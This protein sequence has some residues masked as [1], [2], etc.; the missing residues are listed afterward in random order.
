MSLLIA[1]ES[2]APPPQVESPARP[3]L[4]S[5]VV[6]SPAALAAGAPAASVDVLSGPVHLLP[7]HEGLH[8]PEE[9]LTTTRTPGFDGATLLDLDDRA[10]VS[11]DPL[12]VVLPLS[13]AAPDADQLWTFL[14]QFRD[15]LNG[16]LWGDAQLA[17]SF[18]DGSTWQLRFRHEAAQGDWQPRRINHN[19]ASVIVR[20]LALDPLAYGPLTS[21]RYATPSIGGGEFPVEYPW[22]LASGDVIGQTNPLLVGGSELAWPTVTLVGPGTRLTTVREGAGPAGGQ[23]PGYDVV[24]PLAAGQTLTIRHNPRQPRGQKRVEGPAGVSW[25]RYLQPG[26]R[27]WPLRPG[28]E[29][30]ALAVDDATSETSVT[31]AWQPARRYLV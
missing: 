20:G 21:I 31:F 19:R 25:F 8:G 17:A 30:I 27:L 22:D 26:W 3:H 7:G 10:G 15:C 6:S 11:L 2:T 4:T 24:R 28:V 12:T 16:R 5:L 9:T 1:V 23:G 29:S 18:T 13:I 14:H